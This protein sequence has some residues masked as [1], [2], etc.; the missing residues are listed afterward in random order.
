MEMVLELEKKYSLLFNGM[1]QQVYDEAV[2]EAYTDS[3]TCC[4]GIPLMKVEVENQHFRQEEQT[5][6]IKLNVRKTESIIQEADSQIEQVFDL[7]P[8]QF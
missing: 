4:T 5:E 8:F 3:P 1:F 7:H 6:F 2:E